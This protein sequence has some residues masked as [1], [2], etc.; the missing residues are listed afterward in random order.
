MVRKQFLWRVNFILI[1]FVIVIPFVFGSCSNQAQTTS[2]GIKGIVMLG[3]VSPVEKE[4]EANEEPY[5]DALI[6]I[7][8]AS[9]KKITEV[10]SDKDGRFT[11]NLLPG[12]YT[13]S[14]QTPKDQ[15][16]PVGESQEVNVSEKAFTEVTIHYDSGIR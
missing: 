2:S 12:K 9:G 8:D 3:P 16:L 14:P 11:V 7:S 10:K 5:P 13:L 6:I 15:I 4:G 1:L